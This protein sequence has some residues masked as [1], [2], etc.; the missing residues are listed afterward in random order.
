MKFTTL[1]PTTWNDGRPVDPDLLEHLIDQLAQ[2]FGG[3][4]EEGQ[5]RGIWFDDDGTR[6]TDRSIKVSIECDRGLLNEA[7]KRVRAIGRRLRQKAMY[8]EV[9]GYDGVQFLRM[10]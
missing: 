4:T 7:I 6:D 10:N 8:F 9:S 1:I 2:P 3:M 5:V